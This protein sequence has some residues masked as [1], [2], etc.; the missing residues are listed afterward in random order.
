LRSLLPMLRSS[1]SHEGQWQVVDNCL[2]TADEFGSTSMDGWA[3]TPTW[4]RT[5]TM[6]PRGPGSPTTP[7]Q[8]G[9]VPAWPGGQDQREL[10]P[11]LRRQQLL[12]RPWGNVP[13]PIGRQ[14]GRTASRWARPVRTCGSSSTS[15][16]RICSC[17]PGSPTPDQ[18]TGS[19]L[20][21][22][23]AG[24]S[25]NTFV[26]ASVGGTSHAYGRRT[27]LWLAN[28]DNMV[29][30]SDGVGWPSYAVATTPGKVTGEV[31]VYD[32]N[33]P[34]RAMCWSTTPSP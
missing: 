4:S 9:A 15:A 1:A 2:F 14:I 24:T 28:T 19:R 3:C 12:L 33:G 21:R 10:Q 17:P 5:A 22:S 6:M 26:L 30:T 34:S 27:S 31:P 18:T 7:P 11:P 8:G 13:T 20:V 29:L 32:A 16:P 25:S 23:D